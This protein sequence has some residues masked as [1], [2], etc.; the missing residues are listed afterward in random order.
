MIWKFDF[1]GKYRI[2]YLNKVNLWRN[3]LDVAITGQSLIIA[4]EQSDLQLFAYQKEQETFMWIKTE[5][6]MDHNEGLA[7]IDSYQDK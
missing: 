4:F 1:E 6:Y 3:A 5:N 2:K 7:C